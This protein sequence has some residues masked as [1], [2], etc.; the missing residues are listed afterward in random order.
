MTIRAIFVA[1]LLLIIRCASAQDDTVS[2]AEAER[3]FSLQP[4]NAETKAYRHTW[5]EFNNANHLDEKDDCYS[6]ADGSLVQI[7]QIDS[8]GKVVGY[9]ADKDNGRSQ[10]WRRTYMGVIF[11]KPPFAP[12]YHR[13]EMQ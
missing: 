1:A 3:A 12:F 6:K 5:E 10:C 9:F 7:L 8:E 11:P 4:T 13:L 2:F